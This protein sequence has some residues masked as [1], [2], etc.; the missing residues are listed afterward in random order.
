VLLQALLL[1]VRVAALLLVSPLFQAAKVP[2][3]AQILL[4]LGLSLALSLN[5]GPAPL[6]GLTTTGAWIQAIGIEFV[7]GATLGL[8]VSLAL[9]TFSV[10]GR[11][12]DIQIGFGLA[13]VFDPGTQRQVS[14][15]DAAFTR[16]GVLLFLVLQGHHALL[17]ALA[18]SAERFPPGSNWHLAWAA[19][20][21]FAQAAGLFA[22][23]FALAAPVV[24]CVLLVELALGVLG[25]N[26]PQM[27]MFVLALPVK[28]VVGLVALS[29][30]FMAIG[31][32]M[33][34]VYATIEAAWSQVLQPPVPAM[35]AVP[36]T[37]QGGH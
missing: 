8:G 22:L 3:P 12:L 9:A 25:R 27:N 29:L 34:R 1:S 28:V 36:A 5:L 24:F 35:P 6:Q 30:W 31:G 21:V 17:R 32:V 33:T 10:A 2:A 18:L 14:V 20:A 13:Q 11:L 4:V 26:L 15:L 7:L 23:G 19:D 37:P 16:L